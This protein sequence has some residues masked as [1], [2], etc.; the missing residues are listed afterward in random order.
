MAKTLL[1]KISII[2]AGNVGTSLAM[3]FFDKGYPIASV[4]GRTGTTALSLAKAVKCKKASTQVEDIEPSTEII[5]IAVSDPAI[6]EIARTLARNKK[7][8]FKKLF[9]C[10]TSGV[11]TSAILQPLSKKGALTASVHPIQTFSAGRK[12]TKVQGIF[13]GIEGSTEARSKAIRLVGDIG[14]K[15]IVLPPELKPL[16]HIACV[17]A[18][19]YTIV[20]LNAIQELAK[21]LHINAPWTEVF[22]PLMTTAMENTIK[23]SA[24]NALTGPVTRNDLAT[25][26]THLTALSQSAPQFLPMYTVAGI[27][28]ARIAKE[29]GKVTQEE[30]QALIT[31]FRQFIRSSTPHSKGRH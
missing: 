7:L 20:I 29:H 9:V 3:A 11:F 16:Y 2:G 22:G 27:E 5:L 13:F 25:I 6:G 17:F 12:R 1:P 8:K 19:S 4:I 18:S 10:H 21:Q 24:A 23:Y 15:A 14:G 31:E 28:V 26:K 30:F